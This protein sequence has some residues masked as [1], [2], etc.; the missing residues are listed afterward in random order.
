MCA[1]DWMTL[2]QGGQRGTEEAD[3]KLE[4]L[5]TEE[6]MDRLRHQYWRAAGFP[7][8]VADLPPEM[9]EEEE[10]G[11]PFENLDK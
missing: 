3:M 7:A 5:A 6:G 10:E 9:E 4:D 11:H 1:G 2:D 8:G